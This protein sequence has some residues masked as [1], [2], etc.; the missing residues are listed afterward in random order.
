MVEIDRLAV[1]LRPKKPFIDWLNTILDEQKVLNDVVA[2]DPTVV[3]IPIIEND[4]ELGEY[5]EQHYKA[6]LEH[7]FSSW[8]INQ[9]D[10]PSR[11]DFEAF[12]E[13]FEINVHSLVIDNVMSDYDAGY[14]ETV[15]QH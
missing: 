4:D 13:F 12:H 10:W 8:C 14:D 15:T 7:E 6:W 11:R 1:I 3:L 5:I 2:A 9:E